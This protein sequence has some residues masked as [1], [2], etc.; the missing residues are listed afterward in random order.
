MV[1]SAAGTVT[2]MLT[3]IWALA[4][5][6]ISAIPVALAMSVVGTAVKVLRNWDHGSD[7]TYQI[8]LESRIYLTSALVEFSLV[9]QMMG[10]G[11]MVMGADHF[12]GILTGAMCA[13]G[14]L[15]ANSW[16]IPALCIKLGLLFCSLAW[17]TLHRLDLQAETFPL[18]KKK[19]VLYLLMFPV[20]IIDLGL[21]SLYLFNLDPDIVTSCCGV[22]FDQELRD[23]Y[24]LLGL[25]ELDLLL[26]G[27]FI[28]LVVLM[29]LNLLLIN[30][31]RVVI[32]Y[33]K[34]LSIAVI[35]GWLVLYIA[36]LVVVTV[37]VSP[38]VYAMPHHRCPFDLV[39]WPYALV[40]L[41]LYLF[42]HVGCGA[43]LVS[44]IAMFHD[45]A[46]GLFGKT[47]SIGKIGGYL[48][49]ISISGFASLAILVVLKYLLS[50]GE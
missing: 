8:Q 49:V 24:N 10:V 11:V 22:I 30:D 50:G 46:Q 39:Q 18:L 42:L 17:V 34:Y 40:G 29:I 6:S 26:P 9:T 19:Y 41:P 16:G 45:T 13:T 20:L 12:S 27:Y 32:R 15:T 37:W 44:G 33:H 21:T 4:L 14:A 23:G 28:G 5:L 7:S 35:I 38:Y 36:S 48:A 47:K 43:G 25:V 3:D 1:V 2:D 31:F